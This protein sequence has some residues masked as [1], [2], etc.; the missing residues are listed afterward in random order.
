MDRR[1][2]IAGAAALLVSSRVRQRK[3]HLA[4][5]VC[6]PR[7][8]TRKFSKFGTRACVIAAGLTVRT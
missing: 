7:L 5:L 3:G 1:D 6:L 8:K 2:F 4:G